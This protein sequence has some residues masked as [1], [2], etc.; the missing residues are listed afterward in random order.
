MSE[1]SIARAAGIPR[2]TA[3]V[4]G[5]AALV[6]LGGGV[7]TGHP[8]MGVA[9][10]LGMSIGAANGFLARRFLEAGISFAATSLARLVVLTAAALTA[11]I[12]LG[13]DR[14]YLVVAGV[15]ISQFILVGVAVSARRPR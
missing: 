5:A 14:V 13:L 12:L 11:G 3:V 1:Q 4:C 10:A 7:A 8:L 15:A 6:A 9:L 2:T